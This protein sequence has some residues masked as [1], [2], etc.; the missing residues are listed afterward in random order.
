MSA[1]GT[2]WPLAPAAAEPRHPRR[3]LE[4]FL[5]VE[6][7]C[8]LA[9]L[10]P[11]LNVGPLRVVWRMGV[12]VLSIAL[13]GLLRGKR[14]AA[15]AAVAAFWVM[16]LITLELFHPDGNTVL[17]VLAQW[18]MYLAVL[19][20]LFWMPRLDISPRMLRRVLLLYW[21]FYSISAAVG[22]LQVYYPNRF[23]PQISPFIA[24]L[25][26]N[27]AGLKIT[28]ANGAVIFRPQGLTD[29]PGGA[30]TAGMWAVLFGLGFVLTIPAGRL[31]PLKRGLFLASMLVGVS[32]IYL[33]QVRV[34]L[35]VVEVWML[36]LLVFL[37]WRRRWRQFTLM[38]L[39]G[40]MI[41]GGAWLMARRVGGSSM[42][43]RV[44]TVAGAR[45]TQHT[46]VQERGFFIRE[47]LNTLIPE[48]PLGAGL[49]RWGMMNSYFGDN[50]NPAR[51]RVY[52]EI[53]WQGW[54]LDGGVPLLLA[55]LAL[56]AVA[57][58]SLWRVARRPGPIAVWALL[59]LAYDVAMVA[60]SFDYTP[61]TAELGLEFW[62]VNALVLAA[63]AYMQRQARLQAQSLA[64]SGG[65]RG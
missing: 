45:N 28:L 33:S 49:G 22:L 30:A 15:P 47:T 40:T 21:G 55:Y 24:A 3:V 60:L 13:I 9:L 2:A 29:T 52:V 27:V 32:C 16:A 44:A 17:A 59:C 43:E 26:E 31:Q 12:F 37:M 48:Y 38:A 62:F 36:A 41:A 4:G 25:G 64:V 63:A 23:Q 14:R 18:A 19:A 35:V 61:F 34:L 5:A 6:F 8:Q 39:M 53:Q 11:A 57:M 51:G 7:L 10:V 1:P 56:L 42:V 20:P 65:W 46:F 50:T 58:T 54:V